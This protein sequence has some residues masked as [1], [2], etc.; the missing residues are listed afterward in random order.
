MIGRMSSLLR[1]KNVSKIFRAGATVLTEVS[2]DLPMKHTAAIVGR[3][4]TGKSTF[5]HLAAGIDLPTSGHVFLTGRDLSGLSETARTQCRRE[6]VGLVFQFFYLLSHLSVLEN[7]LLPGFIAGSIGAE[8]QN[9]GRELLD[10][11]GL[12]SRGQDSPRLLSGGEMQRVALC[13]ALL[14]KPRLV[15]AD[16]PTGNLDDENSRGVMDLLFDLVEREGSSLVMVTHSQ[17]LA[18]RAQEQWRLHAGRL[19]RV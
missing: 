14:L 16:E 10:R 12:L 5:L 1:F 17:E 15:L 19:E 2:F 6:N 11:V 8:I 13:R 7:V 3:S 18:A 9:R 4:G